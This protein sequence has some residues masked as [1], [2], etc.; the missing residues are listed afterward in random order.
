M[1][2]LKCGSFSFRVVCDRCQKEFLKP[3]IEFKNNILSFYKYEEISFLIKYK[4]EKF[5]SRVFWILGNVLKK[6]AINFNEKAFVIPINDKIKKGYS[7]TAILA[8]CMH[9]KTLTPL[10][11]VLHSQHEVE[12]AG[13]TLEFRL[14]NPRNFKYTGPKNIYVILVD[15]VMTTG[16][17]LKE[18]KDVLKK[19]GVNVLFSVV[20][21]KGG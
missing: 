14:N 9:T 18:A 1:K 3:E 12:Y 15:D 2:C 7:H 5:G 21:A 17:T 13:K 6:F 8:K 16:L 4:Y 10:F 20:L 11:S 19:N